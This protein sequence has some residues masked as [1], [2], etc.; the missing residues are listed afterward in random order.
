M[1]LIRIPATRETRKLP[2]ICFQKSRNLPLKSSFTA[3]PLMLLMD[4]TS[5]S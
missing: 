5:S 2:L 1:M 3:V 4:P